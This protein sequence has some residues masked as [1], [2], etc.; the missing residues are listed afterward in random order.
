MTGEV[1]YAP[2][3]S[4]VIPTYERPRQLDACLRALSAQQYPPS[5]FEV[6]VVDDGSKQPPR[7][8][9]S[10]FATN[11]RVRLLEQRN[12]GPAAA[13]NHGASAARGAH[14][15]F[16]DD[17]CQPD[18][19]WLAALGA[20]VAENPHAAVG[21]RIENALPRRLCSTASQILIDFLYRYY[22]SKTQSSTFLITANVAFPR[23]MFEAMGGFDVSFPLAAGEDRDLCERWVGAGH[24][25]VYTND[26][27]VAHAHDL[28]LA[29]FC[30][31]HFNYGR[32][33]HHLHR[34]RARRGVR[35]FRLESL[36]FYTQLIVAPFR[37]ATTVRSIDLSALLLLSQLSYAVG[38]AL[39]R[40]RWSL[41]ERKNGE[42]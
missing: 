20:C 39:E 29:S 17:D 13:R 2:L 37:T 5:A 1:S 3:F 14:V 21:G 18:P 12:V 40:V 28:N 30:K 35:G 34:A 24:A 27:V 25:M 15:V 16:T 9:V 41:V 38:Y 32:G 26:A 11:V 19:L 42:R 10:R 8:I 31:Q 23:L 7:E 6:I 33:A 22:N 36:Q 4:V